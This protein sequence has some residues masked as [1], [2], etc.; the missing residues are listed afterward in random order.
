MAA[1]L[2]TF[3]RYNDAVR[4]LY[5]SFRSFVVQSCDEKNDAAAALPPICMLLSC[6]QDQFVSRLEDFTNETWTP[7]DR[8]T[9]E[10]SIQIK[11]P[12]VMLV[13]VGFFDPQSKQVYQIERAV[14]DLVRRQQNT[15][16]LFAGMAL[17]L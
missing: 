1:A 15:L 13:H 9:A 11:I 5:F 3:S 2:A 4:E 17:N 10:Q 8:W 6:T 7:S 14:S 12:Y 16:T